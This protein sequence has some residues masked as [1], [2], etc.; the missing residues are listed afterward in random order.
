MKTMQIKTIK[1]YEEQIEAYEAK[2]REARF[3]FNDYLRNDQDFQ[4]AIEVVEKFNETSNTKFRLYFDE[5][6]TIRVSRI[7]KKEECNTLLYF[8]FHNGIP[9]I[10]KLPDPSIFG[11]DK[12]SEDKLFDDLYPLLAKFLQ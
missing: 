4:K 11:V 8:G 12:T 9:N 1:D 10:I 2:I 5:H 6:Y 3:S 7:E